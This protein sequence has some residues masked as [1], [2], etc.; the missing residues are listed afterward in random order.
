ME[1]RERLLELLARHSYQCS[2]K[3]E[4]KLASGRFSRFYINC[5]TTTMRREAAPLIEAAF[6]PF[7]PKTAE[8]VGGLTMGADPIAYAIRDLSHQDLDAFVVRKAAKE[9]GL[10]KLIEGPVKPGMRVVVVDDVVTTGCSTVTAIEECTSEELKVIAVVVLVDRQEDDGLSR[11]REVAGGV[12]V[13]AIFNREE[14]H[15]RW[16]DL[17]TDAD[18][19]SPRSSATAG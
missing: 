9:H 4:F 6:R 17:R 14:V 2:D 18:S 11:I 13:S 12:P 10:K 5:K 15:L 16:L 7:I 8:A 19:S 1:E 3:P